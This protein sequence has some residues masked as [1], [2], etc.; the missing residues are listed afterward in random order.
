MAQMDLRLMRDK[1]ET[2]STTEKLFQVTGS[3]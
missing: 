1:K 2:G 3:K